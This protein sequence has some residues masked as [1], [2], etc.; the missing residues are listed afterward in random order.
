[1]ENVLFDKLRKC[2]F[3][4]NSLVISFFGIIFA[5]RRFHTTVFSW[6]G[7]FWTSK[8]IGMS[9]LFS[10]TIRAFDASMSL[11]FAPYLSGSWHQQILLLP[12]LPDFITKKAKDHNSKNKRKTLQVFPIRFLRLIPVRILVRIG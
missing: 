4:K 11:S 3:E 6:A 1:M 9:L 5:L 12:S 10:E 2:S 8:P 7:N